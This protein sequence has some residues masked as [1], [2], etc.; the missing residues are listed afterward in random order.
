MGF[1]YIILLRVMGSYNWLPLLGL[2]SLLGPKAKS[3][4][5]ASASWSTALLP[6]ER[7]L[8]TGLRLGHVFSYFT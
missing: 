6:E 8:I 7:K 3:E 5:D 2:N 1:P 4:D